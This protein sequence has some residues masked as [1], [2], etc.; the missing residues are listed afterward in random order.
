MSKLIND[1]VEQSVN[2]G[3]NCL[4]LLFELAKKTVYNNIYSQ[5]L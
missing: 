3:L 5:C 2:S 1:R 4:F